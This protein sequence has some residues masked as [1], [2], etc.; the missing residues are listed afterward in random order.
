MQAARAEGIDSDSLPDFLE[1][2]HGGEFQLLGQ[3]ELG[4]SEIDE[5][6]NQVEDDGDESES[7][8]ER[9][10]LAAVRAGQHLFAVNVLRNC[11]N[12]CVFCGLRPSTFGGRRMLIAGHIKPWRDSTP[13]ERLDL[14]NGLAACPAH[15]VAFDTGLITI[16]DDMHVRFADSLAA[17]TCTDPMVKHF[18]GQPPMLDTIQLPSWADLPRPEYLDWHRQHVFVGRRP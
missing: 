9:I 16:D 12:Q 8:T 15:D 13:R 14:R 7:E 17:A 6:R 18:Y 3:D 10:M 4:P 2:E 5:L 11:G 1:L